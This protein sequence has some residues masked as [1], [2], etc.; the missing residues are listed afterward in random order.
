[1]SQWMILEAFV[2]QDLEDINKTLLQANTSAW[3]MYLRNS[4]TS[5]NLSSCRTQ[6]MS[7]IFV[8][9]QAEEILAKKGLII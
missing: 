4:Q 5:V 6:A 8:D 2:S 7:F 3:Q 9:T 1:M